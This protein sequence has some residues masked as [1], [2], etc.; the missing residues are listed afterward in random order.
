MVIR[1]P[2]RKQCSIRTRTRQWP[3]AL[4]PKSYSLVEGNQTIEPDSVIFD[5]YQ[6][7]QNL[8]HTDSSDWL[9][10]CH[11]ILCSCGI[12]KLGV[13][14]RVHCSYSNKSYLDNN[15]YAPSFFEVIVWKRRWLFWT[16]VFFWGSVAPKAKYRGPKQL[17]TNSHNDRKI[18]GAKLLLSLIIAILDIW[19]HFRCNL[20]RN[21]LF[22]LFL[23]SLS[24]YPRETISICPGMMIIT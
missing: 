5:K 8:T 6:Y 16:K 21:T 4:K 9:V 11:L 19:M 20:W 24:I 3:E 7:C 1:K 14:V 22:N 17:L 18:D 2:T 23:H 12:F 15:N 10:R 13:A